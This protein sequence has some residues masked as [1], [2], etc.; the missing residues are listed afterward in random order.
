M[1]KW[2][3][4][5]CAV[6]MI[7]ISCTAEEEIAPTPSFEVERY[8]VAE[9]G[10]ADITAP[11]PAGW[12]Y[13][14]I[15]ETSDY[16]NEIFGIRFWPT[17]HPE[18]SV[19]IGWRPGVSVPNERSAGTIST[20]P[21]HDGDSLRRHSKRKGEDAQSVTVS[22]LGYPYLYIADYILPDALE[23]EY[24]P[25]IREI[26]CFTEFGRIRPWYEARDLVT[27]L[28]DDYYFSGY[29]EL[30][31]QTGTWKIFVDMTEDGPRRYFKVTTDGEITEYNP[32]EEWE[33]T[34]IMDSKKVR[35]Y[36]ETSIIKKMG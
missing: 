17:E 7:L 36:N 5:I 34:P 4:W 13:S 26:L 2:I 16:G 33:N 15:E 22:W 20:V 1:K 29:V 28:L 27:D 21:C 25:V 8:T 12:D 19:R 35:T 9:K 32:A 31:L 24:E 14:I 10:Y 3:L 11:L 18:L 23:A 6:W 30:D